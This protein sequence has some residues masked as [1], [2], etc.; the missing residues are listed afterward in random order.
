MAEAHILRL[1][2]NVWFSSQVKQTLLYSE[3]MPIW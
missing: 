2:N 3:D 1:S